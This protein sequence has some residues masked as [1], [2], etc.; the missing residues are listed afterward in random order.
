MNYDIIKKNLDKLDKASKTFPDII[1][2]YRNS[3]NSQEKRNLVEIAYNVGLQSYIRFI[4]WIEIC[5]EKGQSVIINYTIPFND[6]KT[7]LIESCEDAQVKDFIKKK[8]KKGFITF[9]NS[10]LFYTYN[11]GSQ[12]RNRNYFR[13]NFSKSET[14]IAN[15]VM[16]NDVKL[17]NSI[18]SQYYLLEISNFDSEINT[19]IEI[20]ND[21]IK[22]LIK[23]INTI[24]YDFR[25]LN[26]NLLQSQIGERIKE[27]VL[28]VDNGEQIKC[29]E[30]QHALTLNKI[31]NVE[32]YE[33]GSN[34]N[35][36]VS[37]K[38]DN[39]DRC[40]YNYRLFESVSKLRESN[41]NNILTFLEN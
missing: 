1:G 35:L 26:F 4:D 19:E 23:K 18:I 11:G 10:Q 14:L 29:I 13:N 30:A 12:G 20:T 37:I 8:T 27:R 40:N 7:A 22:S 36:I 5:T 2:K 24:K 34:G 39:N 31:Y 33:I 3:K 25:K 41:I 9:L 28:S 17:T 6:F 32:G 16:Q 38:N 15:W 21:I